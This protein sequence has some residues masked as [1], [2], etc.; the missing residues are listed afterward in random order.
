MNKVKFKIIPASYLVLIKNNNILLLRRYNTG[1][2]D[3]NYSFVAG[4]L[5]G[6]ETF[7]EAM[8][9]EAREEAGIIL[10]PDWLKVV[11]V[12]QRSKIGNNG[13][14]V[15]V[16]LTADEWK[17]NIGN[18][19]PDKCDDLGWFPVDH[20][21]DNTIPFIRQAIKCI[22]NNIFYSEFGF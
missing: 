11:H 9:R 13:E 16:F 18:L 3:G 1:Y 14:R 21:P 10:D 5:E 22:N 6:E 8:A 19:E 2:E 15:D 7:R 20:L 17:G 12:M 4:H